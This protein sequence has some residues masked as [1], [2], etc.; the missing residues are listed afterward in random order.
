MAND[1]RN[2]S[3]IRGYGTDAQALS[4]N[5]ATRIDSNGDIDAVYIDG[6]FVT[7]DS[8]EFADLITER[9]A[10]MYDANADS[11]Y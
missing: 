3:I 6:R 4:L 11:C 10:S 2:I 1:E 5:H 8:I 7:V 9:T